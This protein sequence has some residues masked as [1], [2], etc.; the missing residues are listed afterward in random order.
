MMTEWATGDLFRRRRGLDARPLMVR[1]RP[2]NGAP[3]NFACEPERDFAG[4]DRSSDLVVGEELSRRM[5]GR[6]GDLHFFP[7]RVEAVAGDSVNHRNKGLTSGQ[8]G[9]RLVNEVEG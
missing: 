6:E 7:D 5:T 9:V 3:V 2:N 1:L 8:T 4:S